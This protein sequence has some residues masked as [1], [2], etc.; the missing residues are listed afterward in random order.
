MTKIYEEFLPD[1]GHIGP[2][3]ETVD[4]PTTQDKGEDHGAHESTSKPAPILWATGAGD[5]IRLGCKMEGN[6]NLKSTNDFL[7]LQQSSQSR[8]VGLRWGRGWEGHQSYF[9]PL[10]TNTEDKNTKQRSDL[11]LPSNWTMNLTK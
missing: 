5:S 7:E 9:W 6:A 10:A 1:V 4:Q 3:E 2:L 11:L 8:Q